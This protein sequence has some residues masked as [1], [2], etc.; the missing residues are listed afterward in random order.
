MKTAHGLC[1]FAA[2]LVVLMDAGMAQQVEQDVAAASEWIAISFSP[3]STSELDFVGT[4]AAPGSS[5]E[6]DVKISDEKT[7]IRGKFQ[8]LPEP[9]SLGPFAVYILWVVTPGGRAINIGMLT[10]DGDHGKIEAETPLS[11]FALIVTAEPHF[12]VSVPSKIVVLQNIGRNAKGNTLPVTSLAVRE[13]Y[14]SLKKLVIDKKHPIPLDLE[15]ARYAVA[16]AETAGA[17]ELATAAY[18]RARGA[19]ASAEAEFTSK[20]SSERARVEED[21]REAIQAGEDARAGAEV[22][23]NGLKFLTQADL[24]AAREKTI[25]DEQA[26]SAHLQ[27]ELDSTRQ[28]LAAVQKLLPSA[29]TRVMLASEVLSKW[30]TVPPPSES[31]LMVHVPENMFLKGSNELVPDM[32]QRLSLATGTLLGIG[33]L[34]VSVSPSVQGGD[35]VQKLAMSQQRARAVMEWL[36]SMGVT[37]VMGTSSPDAEASMA[38][39]PGIDLWVAGSGG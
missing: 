4:P 37:S 27:A 15:M 7:V 24:I 16:A 28:K 14:G 6:V 2:G 36:S 34:S 18:D 29:N 12:A 9:S 21:A 20:K 26:K 11:S 31:G 23:R 25:A 13:D 38:M 3:D 5:G 19:L 17:K 35:D 10:R 30:F 1:G 8:K 33:G 22:R 39:G 32:K